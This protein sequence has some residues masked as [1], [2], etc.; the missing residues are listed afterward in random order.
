MIT[1]NHNIFNNGRCNQLKLWLTLARNLIF[2]LNVGLLRRLIIKIQI[3]ILPNTRNTFLKHKYVLNSFVQK[4]P[5]NEKLLAPHQQLHTVLQ[6]A[7]PVFLVHKRQQRLLIHVRHQSWQCN[8]G[9][10]EKP[11]DKLGFLDV[12]FSIFDHFNEF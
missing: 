12:F 9:L 11:V 10:G 4:F 2:Q 8:E 5:C 3:H 1:Q 7:L 6:S